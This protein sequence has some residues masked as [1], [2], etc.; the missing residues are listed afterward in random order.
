MVANENENGSDNGNGKA[1][2]ARKPSELSVAVAAQLRAERAA[3]DMTID[4]L[5]RRSHVSRN[6]L[7][8]VLKGTRV[9]DVSQVSAICRA[10]GV[11]LVEMFQRAEQRLPPTNG[12]NETHE[13]NHPG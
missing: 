5:V 6:A 9:A 8:Q 10:L 11:P 12:A 1:S 2:N 3:A 7:I 4:E 13:N